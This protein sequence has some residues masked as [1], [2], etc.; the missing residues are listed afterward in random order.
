MET[1]LKG[2]VI[3]YNGKY[4]GITRND[5][6]FKPEGWTDIENAGIHDP[7]FCKK[8]ID[9][10]YIDSPYIP[11]LEK[12]KLVNVTKTTITTFKFD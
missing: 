10:A 6:H 9:A 8:P 12:G 11:E 3:E 4:W 2:V 5:G 7:K 1:I